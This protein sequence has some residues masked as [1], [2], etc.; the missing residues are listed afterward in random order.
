MPSTTVPVAEVCQVAVTIL[1]NQPLK[2][3]SFTT[4]SL[5]DANVLKTDT[6][7]SVKNAKG[8]WETGIRF[9]V[10]P[11]AL[12]EVDFPSLNIA[13]QSDGKEAVLLTPP[14]KLSVINPMGE[15]LAP[16]ELKDI[17]GP[18]SA[19][20]SPWIVALLMGIV[21][22][23]LAAWVISRRKKNE[24]EFTMPA[25][26]PRPAAEVALEKL[27]AALLSYN[28]SLDIKAFY[29]ELSMIFRE[30]L[31]RVYAMDAIEKTTSEISGELRDKG[32]DRKICA[33][34]KTLLSACD[35]VKFAKWIPSEKDLDADFARA[36]AFIEETFR[37]ADRAEATK[38]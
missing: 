1:S 2:I 34:A 18:V 14:A 22:A 13:Y 3:S 11:L 15:G 16:V 23:G 8:D 9:D 12:G 35:L 4:P 31:G 32:V 21:L 25:E 29:S 38:V 10:M 28:K 33:D 37:A 17:K 26:P 20:I 19:G 27:E 30:Y 6:I 24:M 36:Q 5:P 7:K